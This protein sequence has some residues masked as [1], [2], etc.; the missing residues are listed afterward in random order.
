MMQTDMG[1]D[2]AAYVLN[3]VFSK[4]VRYL[5]ARETNYCGQPALRIMMRGLPM[6][7][8]EADLNGDV[9]RPLASSFI[10]AGFLVR[11][12]EKALE[13]RNEPA[14]LIMSQNPP[15]KPWYPVLLNPDAAFFK[16][17]APALEDALK[18]RF[19]LS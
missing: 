9:A 4:S 3:E 14:L 6:A 19:S 10:K 2:E 7:S 12:Y 8:P 16:A 15:C 13:G 1:L 18:I 17:Q 5:E 11:W